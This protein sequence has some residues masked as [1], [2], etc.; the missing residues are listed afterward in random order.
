M[1]IITSQLFVVC[2]LDWP[3]VEFGF[4]KALQYLYVLS[5]AHRRWNYWSL[6]AWLFINFCTKDFII[7]KMSLVLTFYVR[8]HSFVFIFTLLIFSTLSGELWLDEINLTGSDWS[9]FKV[10]PPGGQKL[11]ISTCGCASDSNKF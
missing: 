7:S 5:T 11:Q 3:S 6:N 8:Q 10:T 4:L 1:Y 9:D 2:W